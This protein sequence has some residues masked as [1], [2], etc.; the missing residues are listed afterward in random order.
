MLIWYILCFSWPIF[1]S[2]LPQQNINLNNSAKLGLIGKIDIS[3][4]LGGKCQSW[5]WCQ[6]MCM[7]A[8]TCASLIC[9][10]PVLVGPLVHLS[11]TKSKAY[12]LGKIGSDWKGRDIHGIMG[13][14]LVWL[15]CLCMCRQACTHASMHVH[16]FPV[17]FSLYHSQIGWDHRDQG[18]YGI[19]GTCQSCL[20]TLYDL[21]I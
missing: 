21:S 12:Q 17:C 1:L 7:Q 10:M 4:E 14:C 16:H 6:C 5:L 20:S 8:C 19:R 15:W 11:A 18:I 13:V 3:M 9:I 2:V